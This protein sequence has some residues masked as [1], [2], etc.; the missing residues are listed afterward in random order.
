MSDTR[1]FT[2]SLCCV[3]RFP[4]KPVPSALA[5]VP[6]CM[7]VW[8]DL[9]RA[10][11]FLHGGVKGWQHLLKER[12]NIESHQEQMEEEQGGKD[13]CCGFENT[14]RGDNGDSADANAAQ[15]SDAEQM[16]GNVR[17]PQHME[18]GNRYGGREEEQVNSREQQKQGDAVKAEERRSNDAFARLV[19]EM[20]GWG[21]PSHVIHF[22][23]LVLISRGA[24]K[25]LKMPCGTPCASIPPPYPPPKHVRAHTPFTLPKD[26][27][28]WPPGFGGVDLQSHRKCPDKDLSS[29]ALFTPCPS[30]SE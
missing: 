28:I 23:K 6:M 9:Q 13:G 19:G 14:K 11:D 25:V 30:A 1:K 24:A 16:D 26:C 10:R 18:G 7:K 5:G 12:A 8:R 20:E 2:K 4:N 27:C 15:I 3:P 21:Y 22:L 29:V 17:H